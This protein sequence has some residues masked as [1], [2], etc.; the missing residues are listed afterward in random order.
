MWGDTYVNYLTIVSISLYICI[1]KHHYIIC[2]LYLSKAEKHKNKK[3]QNIMLYI[4]YTIFIY[5]NG[6]DQEYLKKG[7]EP[8][9]VCFGLVLFYNCYDGTEL[10]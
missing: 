3:S 10:T 4:L 9:C 1:S 6:K 2:Q 7:I 8:I 5:K